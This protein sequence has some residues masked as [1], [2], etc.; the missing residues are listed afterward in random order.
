VIAIQ[1]SDGVCVS[2]TWLIVVALVLVIAYLALR[3]LGKR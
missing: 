3:I 2:V 1:S